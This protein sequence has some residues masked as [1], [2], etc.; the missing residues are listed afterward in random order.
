MCFFPQNMPNTKKKSAQTRRAMSRELMAIHRAQTQSI[1]IAVLGSIHQGSHVFPENNIGRQCTCTALM[2]LVVAQQ[3][4]P[5]HWTA[6]DLDSILYQGDSLYS[7]TRGDNEYLLVTDLPTSVCYNNILLQKGD[8]PHSDL[9][10]I[11]LMNLS[12]SGIKP[13]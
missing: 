2:S 13:V 12:Y 5:V 8:I 4:S 10:L 11:V 1:S 3:K 6:D 9:T 7:A